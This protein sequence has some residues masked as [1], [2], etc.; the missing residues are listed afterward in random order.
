MAAAGDVSDE[1][2]FEVTR[3]IPV[4]TSVSEQ[5]Q[6]FLGMGFTLA[7]ATQQQ[8]DRTDIE[9]WRGII[10][11]GDDALIGFIEMVPPVPASTVD[12]LAVG[13]ITVYDLLPDG[14]PHDPGGP[15]YLD[16]HG[17]ALIMGGGQACRALATRIAAMTRM[18][19]WSVDYRMAPEDDEIGAETRRFMAKHLAR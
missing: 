11:A 15:I 6:Q 7:D 18:H 2:G 14:V 13:D 16:I 12:I 8:P 3:F 1:A 10:K 4:P 19:T 5:A 17:G 9:S